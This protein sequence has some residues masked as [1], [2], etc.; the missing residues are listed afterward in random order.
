[1]DKDK[2]KIQVKRLYDST[3]TA[4]KSW[5]DWFFERVYRD[6]EVMILAPGGNPVSCLFL[7]QY[8]FRFHG[9]ETR[10]GYISGAA[11]AVPARHKGYMRQLL[12][13]SLQTAHA[14]GDVFVGLIPAT[15]RLYFYYDKFG[16][17]TVVYDDIE[18]YTSVHSF[19]RSDDYSVVAPSYRAFRAL[20]ENESST[21]VHSESDFLAILEDI[22]HDGGVSVQINDK[23]GNQAAMAFATVYDREIHVK[24]LLGSDT[25]ACEMALGEVKTRL[26]TGDKPMVV[27]SEPV[28]RESMLRSRGMMRVVN[29]EAALGT[30]AAANRR[31][32][33]V[34]RVSDRIISE[35]NAIY[36]LKD[37][38][39]HR[40]DSTLRHLTLDVTVD[41]LT[42]I[43]F[44]SSRIGDIFGLPTSR[45]RMS[46]MLD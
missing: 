43:L 42:R 30:L 35:N 33:Q 18:R 27:W 31:I 1:M 36:I 21:V 32:E 34:I 11:T 13:E 46:L 25:A 16:F 6:E 38:K 39:C 20:Q 44:S 9:E 26:G 22:E 45:P 8:K 37:G 29:V 4:D 23:E 24:Y 12:S 15:R 40:V 10:F 3:F 19:T 41:V 7:Q 2:K 17:A 14:R 5:N 28:G